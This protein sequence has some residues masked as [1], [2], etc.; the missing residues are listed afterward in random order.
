MDPGLLV[1][2]NVGGVYF[3]TR[4]Q[5]LHDSSSFFEGLAKAHPTCCELFIDRDPTYFRY[6]LNWMRGIRYLPPDDQALQELAF[7][8]DYYC[9]TDMHNS[10]L[11]S[12][13]R[14]PPVSQTLSRIGKHLHSMAL[15]NDHHRG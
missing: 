10:I 3:V 8:A 5:T 13:N 14:H 15:Q 11:A 12:V 7:E 9:M 6:V 4:R 1:S 2:L